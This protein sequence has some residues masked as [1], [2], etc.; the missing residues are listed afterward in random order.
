MSAHFI[1]HK[2]ICAYEISPNFSPMDDIRLDFLIDKR[3]K[4]R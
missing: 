1:L 3:G 4:E 2:S